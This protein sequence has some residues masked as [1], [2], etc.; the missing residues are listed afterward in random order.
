[1]KGGAA[2]DTPLRHQMSK[3]TSG[4]AIRDTLAVLLREK[5]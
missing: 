5:Y 2:A 4:A 3:E 1:M